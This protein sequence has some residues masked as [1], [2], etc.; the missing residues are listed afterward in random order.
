VDLH[1]EAVTLLDEQYRMH[2]HIMG[3]SSQVFYQNKVK[4]HTSVARHSLFDG[5][6]SLVFVDTAGCGFDEKLDGTSS[7]NPE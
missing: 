5:D 1:P 6:T 3:Y 2:E 7:T 4:A